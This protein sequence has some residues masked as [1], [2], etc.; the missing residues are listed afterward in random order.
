MYLKVAKDCFIPEE[1]IKLYVAFTGNAVRDLVR[2]LKEEGK[3]LD[4]SGKKKALSIVL[5]K[6]GEAV[7]TP[8]SVD[9]ITSRAENWG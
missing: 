3:V 1:N 6:T 7:I 5:L 4:L 2:R 9:T 8:L